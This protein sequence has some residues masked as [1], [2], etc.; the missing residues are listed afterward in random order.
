MLHFCGLRKLTHSR[1]LQSLK[2]VTTHP[3]KH[4]TLGEENATGSQGMTLGG[5]AEPK[6]LLIQTF[7]KE[8]PGRQQ[9]G[10]ER[11]EAAGL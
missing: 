3:V 9:H 7:V 10:P 4:K 11:K 2:L 8:G 6:D 1:P 5:W